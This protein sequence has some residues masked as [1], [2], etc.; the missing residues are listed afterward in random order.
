MFKKHNSHYVWFALMAVLISCKSAY[1]IGYVSWYNDIDKAIHRIS[2]LNGN[3][4]VF[5]EN[6]IDTLPSFQQDYDNSNLRLAGKGHHFYVNGRLIAVFGGCGAVFSVDTS[7]RSITRLDLTIHT[8]YN[9]DA[10][11]FER[12]DTIFSFGG[13]GFWT[14]NNLLTYFSGLRKEWNVY[15]VGTFPPYTP[16]FEEGVTYKFAFYDKGEDVLYVL[17]QNFF[18]KFSFY[19]GEWERLGKLALEN[20]FPERGT[21]GVSNLHRLNDSTVMMMGGLRAYYVI[22]RHN[23]IYDVTMPN[24]LNANTGRRSNP[25]GFHCGYDLENEL[26]LAKF[27]DKI[28]QGYLFEF[29]N[30]L[31]KRINSESQLYSQEILTTE[32]KFGLLLFCFLLIGGF[33]TYWIR[34]LYLKRRNQFFTDVQWKFIQRLDKGGLQTEDLNE[35]LELEAS[36]W[37]VQRR[38]RSEY[39]KMINDL[40]TNQ[41]GCELV[42]RQ[43]SKEDKRQVLYVMNVEAKNKLARLM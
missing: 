1:S 27:S 19:T 32:A 18:Y 42:L 16:D 12:R 7:A 30:R 23:I 33:L 2:V 21:F 6:H 36:S 28:E 39:I 5:Y 34:I 10:Y 31:P 43:R 40:S 17:R 14:E 29:V 38:K 15:S 41:L 3:Y 35:F 4:V 25:L 26:L 22:P 37:E 9:F 11:Q 20:T 8:G 24:G 13:Y